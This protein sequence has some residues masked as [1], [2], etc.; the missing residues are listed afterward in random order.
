[1]LWRWVD[2][3]LSGISQWKQIL[4][5]YQQRKQH[6]WYIVLDAQQS[7]HVSSF[8][9][10]DSQISFS[11]GYC[12]SQYICYNIHFLNWVAVFPNCY[13][14]SSYLTFEL[15]NSDP[16]MLYPPIFVEL[17]LRYYIK[18]GFDLTSHDF[19]QF[20]DIMNFFMTRLKNKNQ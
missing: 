8:S 1:M 15:I 6:V 13:M 11:L 12:H 19:W 4:Y 18:P 17:F 5:Y 3:S 9:S 16:E 10:K 7:F 20:F 14:R 2:H